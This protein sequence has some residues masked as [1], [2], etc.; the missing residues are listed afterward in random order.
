MENMAI[1]NDLQLMYNQL[2][3][4]GFVATVHQ[5]EFVMPQTENVRVVLAIDANSPFAKTLNW[6]NLKRCAGQVWGKRLERNHRPRG[7]LY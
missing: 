6:C 4:M 3:G 5:N 1:V 7:W 2:L